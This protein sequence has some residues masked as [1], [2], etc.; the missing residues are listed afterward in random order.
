[1]RKRILAT[2]LAFA[3]CMGNVLGIYAAEAEPVYE[4]ITTED[5]ISENN[6]EDVTLTEAVSDESFTEEVSISETET[7]TETV[8]TTESETTTE[9]TEEELTLD[10]LTESYGIDFTAPFNGDYIVMTNTNKLYSNSTQSV[11]TLP[12]GMYEDSEIELQE[13]Q[14]NDDEGIMGYDENGLGILDPNSYLPE[15]IINEDAEEEEPEEL[16]LAEIPNYTVGYTRTFYLQNTSDTSKYNPVSCVCVSVGDHCHVWVPED[17]PI[18]LASPSRMRGYMDQVRDSYESNFEKILTGFGTLDYADQYGDQDDKVAFLCYD[19]DGNGVGGGAY[20]AGF[21]FAADLNANYSNKTGNNLDCLHI[22]S[23]QGMGRNTST[24]TLNSP[25]GA[26]GTMMHEMQHMVTWSVCRELEKKNGWS[27][28]SVGLPTWLSEGYAEAARHYCMYSNGNGD[29]GRAQSANTTAWRGQL[30]PIG[31]VSGQLYSYSLSYNFTQYVRIQYAQKTGTSGWTIFRTAM[32]NMGK[33]TDKIA[34]ASGAYLLDSLAKELGVSS[35]ELIRNFWLAMYAKNAEGP[36]GFGGESWAESI[37]IAVTPLNQAATA[38]YPGGSQIMPISGSFIPSGA[39]SSISFAAIDYDTTIKKETLTIS[40]AKD[41]DVIGGTVKLTARTDSSSN[42]SVGWNVI[43]ESESGVVSV[44]STGLVRGLKEGTATIRGFLKNNPSVHSDVTIRVNYYPYY[45]MFGFQ[46][47]IINSGYGEK[48]YSCFVTGVSD[49][50]MYYTLED[51]EATREDSILSADGIITTKEGDTIINVL[52]T[53]PGYNDKHDRVVLSLSKLAKPEIL[54]ELQEDGNVKVTI[55][56]EAGTDIFY[57]VGGKSPLEYGK[58]YEGSISIAATSGTEIKAVARKKGMIDSEITATTLGSMKSVTLN[59]ITQKAEYG[60]Y[61]MKITAKETDVTFTYT[62]DGTEP[63]RSSNVLTSDGILIDKQGTTTFKVT[64]WKTG[65]LPSTKSMNVTVTKLQK[66]QISVDT[67]NDGRFAIKMSSLDA[68]AKI[69]YTLDKSDPLTNG[70]EYT[71]QIVRDSM[72]G[73]TSIKAVAKKL[74]SINSDI[75]GYSCSDIVDVSISD[76]QTEA[77]YG[78]Y[79]AKVTPLE[80]DVEITYTLNG[81]APKKT[82]SKLPSEGILI[83]KQGTTTFTAK[84]WKTNR[85]P[86][87]VSKDITVSD[88]DSPE[89]IVY[90]DDYGVFDLEIV[91]D[92]ESVEIYYTLDG[93]SPL[94]NG[95]KYTD[96][97]E[98]FTGADFSTI[99]AVARK[100]GC[101]DSEI[102]YCDSNDF[103]Y[104]PTSELV[105]VAIDGGYLVMETSP[106][107]DVEFRYTLDGSAP[108]RTSSILPE[109]GISITSLGKTVVTVTAWK[110]GYIPKV[111]SINVTV[112]K[113]EKPTISY[114]LIDFLNQYDI[115]IS[116]AVENSEIYYSIDGADYELYNGSL[117]IDADEEHTLDVFARKIGYVDSDV[118]RETFSKVEIEGKALLYTPRIPLTSIVLNKRFAEDTGEI[119]TVMPYHGEEILECG[120]SGAMASYFDVAKAGDDEI[121]IGIADNT[122][123]VGSYRLTLEMKGTHFESEPAKMATITVRVIDKAPVVKIGKLITYKNYTGFSIPLSVTSVA[124]PVRVIGLKNKIDGFTDNFELCD[125]Y[126]DSSSY[127]SIKMSKSYAE[128]VTDSKKKPVLQGYLTVQVDGYKEQDVLI[129]IAMNNTIPKIA[130]TKVPKYNYQSFIEDGLVATVEYTIVNRANKKVAFDSISDVCINESSPLYTKVQPLLDMTN[131]VSAD[132]NGNVTVHFVLPEDGK[133]AGTHTVPLLVS[134]ISDVGEFVNVPITAKFAVDKQT[135]AV[136]ATLSPAS[137]KLNKQLDDKAY[138][139][140][141]ANY[142]NVIVEDVNC[143]AMEATAKTNLDENVK[144]RY[145]STTSSLVAYF[146]GYTDDSSIICNTYKFECSPVF[147]SLINGAEIESTQK[148]VVTV[149]ITDKQPLISAAAKGSVNVVNRDNTYIKY[150]IKKNGFFAD[151]NANEEYETVSIEAPLKLGKGE[152]DG[153]EIFTL[154]DTADA[155]F[156][157]DRTTSVWLRDDACITRGTKYVIRLSVLLENGEKVYSPDLKITPTQPNVAV[158]QNYVPILFK[159]VNLRKRISTVTLI[160]NVG[161]IDTIEYNA[162]KN[163]KLSPNL[164]PELVDENKDQIAV[165]LDNGNIKPGTYVIHYFVTYKGEMIEKDGSPKKYPISIKVTVK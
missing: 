15:L 143:M 158:K 98:G 151:F 67:T 164:L 4:E 147:K 28:Y 50:N 132:E 34:T 6:T 8:S 16:T 112:S 60:G 22:D 11:G 125:E 127:E 136:K 130:Q 36:Y 58:K 54:P 9:E 103:E 13:I 100:K 131:P 157:S 80:S 18:Y 96:I 108:T 128:L 19:I 17:D 39:A 95:T 24:N 72:A 116:N 37:N 117:M 139:V 115:A 57:T 109:D 82:D 33:S 55:T 104:V 46:S 94:E 7:E 23:W 83:D 163:S 107:E 27:T 155:Q 20:K 45:D 152:A 129:N 78:G 59:L 159:S 146:D 43:N 88:L 61:R 87:V 1:M 56:A 142:K 12:S 73:I 21:F 111:R 86:V 85:N 79:V 162:V 141:T 62:L 65:Y 160:H 5:A 44:D 51:R 69:Y 144:L 97:I 63:T 126:G 123:P 84:A 52:V 42:P 119:I 93:S 105:A 135:S 113:L 68:N 133:V 120:L 102:V 138:S 26:A 10:S 106:E 53:A 122:V 149:S 30:S 99:A 71:G 74:G 25:T 70:I 161:E 90:V 165:T 150:T 32:L 47:N 154:S 3:L 114:R 148:I 118:I 137:L 38:I 40:G 66:P 121:Y 31:F 153:S 140:V 2:V 91:S 29:T 49:V 64:G 124:G 77:V 76:V 101:I 81:V 110:D 48:K 156:M 75:A 145:D 134:G 14:E 89:I 92:D 35:E 41:I